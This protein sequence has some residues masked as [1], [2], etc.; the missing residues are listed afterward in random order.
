[1]AIPLSPSFS[2]RPE[3]IGR[4]EIQQQWDNLPASKRPKLSEVFGTDSRVKSFKPDDMRDGD[5]LL[6]ILYLLADAD[7]P[8]F[9]D[10][11]TFLEQHGDGPGSKF[12][13]SYDALGG[14]MKKSLVEATIK[15]KLDASALLCWRIL[16]DKGKLEE[17]HVRF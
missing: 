15:S 8:G 2:L 3:Q 14:W 10:R 4:A 13:I 9:S 5:L 1:M 11:P 17:K 6:E 7:T 16:Q 12:S